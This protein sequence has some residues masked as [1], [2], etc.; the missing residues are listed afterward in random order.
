MS[1]HLNSVSIISFVACISL[2]FILPSA[3]SIAWA[4]SDIFL[5]PIAAELLLSVCADLNIC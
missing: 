5:K 3:S 4:S 1:M 2:F